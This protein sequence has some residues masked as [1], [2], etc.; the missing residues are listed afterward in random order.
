[1]N[2]TYYDFISKSF[3]ELQ[4]DQYHLNPS[5]TDNAPFS[6][7]IDIDF[8]TQDIRHLSLVNNTKPRIFNNKKSINVIPNK[9]KI[10]SYTA[11]FVG[12]INDSTPS[13][14]YPTTNHYQNK[15][16]KGTLPTPPP[17][18]AE[19]ETEA[20]ADY[21]ENIHIVPA[22]QGFADFC[23]KSHINKTSSP[24]NIP[25]NK[26]QRKGYKPSY[27]GSFSPDKFEYNYNTSFD[28]NTNS[29]IP[30]NFNGNPLPLTYQVWYITELASNNENIKQAASKRMSQS[31]LSNPRERCM[32]LQE[33]IFDVT[34]YL[35]VGF[36]VGVFL[37][38][39]LERYSNLKENECIKYQDNGKSLFISFLV[40]AIKMDTYPSNTTDDFSF[41]NISKATGYLFSPRN[42]ANLEKDALRSLKN[43]LW[44]GYNSF[45]EFVQT[46]PYE[47]SDT[48]VS[49]QQFENR[50]QNRYRKI[51][52]NNL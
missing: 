38:I 17:I 2:Y 18:E 19:I 43:N 34:D 52:L 12:D 44:I 46:H 37:G 1:M 9:S 35:H 31:L 33:F 45:L 6:A 16:I 42:L 29:N 30:I 50:L 39:L 40:I 5:H 4:A 8:M 41:K 23:L 14:I 3:L 22:C 13:L 32:E 26:T 36:L 28:S 48:I 20:E 10:E 7:D 51:P 21:N 24:I 15:T 47:F 11:K 49:Y 25:I 27:I